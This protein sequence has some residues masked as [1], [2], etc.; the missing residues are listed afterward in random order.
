LWDPFLCMGRQE[1]RRTTVAINDGTFK[2]K[3]FEITSR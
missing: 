1:K 2:K 3:T